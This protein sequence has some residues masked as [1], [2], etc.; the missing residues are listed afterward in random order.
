MPR[1]PLARCRAL[2]LAGVLALGGAACPAAGCQAPDP[3]FSGFLERFIHD[4]AF[5]RD[6]TAWP[7]AFEG[8]APDGRRATALTPAEAAAPAVSRL[9][10]PLSSRQL[11]LDAAKNDE[12]W[13]TAS[14]IV[15]D[16][17]SVTVTQGSQGADVWSR[18]HRFTRQGGCWFLVGLR[19]GGL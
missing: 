17:A 3:S 5:R 7:L 10:A 19:V 9:L 11:E 2:A 13:A 8:A 18:T 12:P 6:R 16:K 1:T 15:F 4:A 14:T